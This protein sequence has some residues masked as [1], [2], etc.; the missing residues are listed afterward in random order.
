[1]S[2][3]PE[4]FRTTLTARCMKLVPDLPPTFQLQCLNDTS[5]CVY[6]SEHAVA[7][8]S[9]PTSSCSLENICGHGGFDGAAPDREY[10]ALRSRR[11]EYL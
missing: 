1:M 6:P 11:R 7:D 5:K 8:R 2:D 10:P 9:P 4:Y 3:S